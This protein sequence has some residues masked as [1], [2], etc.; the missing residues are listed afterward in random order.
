PHHVPVEL[1]RQPHSRHEPASH[2]GD[3]ALSR[4]NRHLLLSPLLV[5]AAARAFPRKRLRLRSAGQGRGRRPPPGWPAAAG[6]P[7][8]HPRP[9]AVHASW[10]PSASVGVGRVLRPHR[11]RVPAFPRLEPHGDPRAPGGHGTGT[12]RLAALVLGPRRR[13]VVGEPPGEH[14]PRRRLHQHERTRRREPVRH[15]HPVRT[16]RHRLQVRL[17]PH[18]PHP[19]PP[20]RAAPEPIPTPPPPP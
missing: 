13:L 7:S 4:P 12:A 19:P 9:L 16:P 20:P 2:P 15:P 8:T 3:D 10:V 6:T 11:Q 5:P 1:A 17:A 14:H 18:P